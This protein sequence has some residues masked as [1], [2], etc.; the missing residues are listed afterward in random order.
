MRGAKSFQAKGANWVLC[1]DFN[2]LCALEDELDM[3]A[4]ELGARLDGS[5]GKPRRIATLMRTVYRI[6]LS[7]NHPRMTDHEAGAI[8]GELGLD[9]AA[10]LL[11]EAFKAAF[12]EVE[13][14]AG[15]DAADR[16]LVSA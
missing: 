9:E 6:G 2:T 13:G 15:A 3:S 11:G 8:V 10:R 12:P 7:G 14:G 5:D 4:D 16:P 1:F